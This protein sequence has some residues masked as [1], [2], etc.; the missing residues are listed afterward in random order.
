M[1]YG[2]GFWRT[3]GAKGLPRTRKAPSSF[4]LRARH[5]ITALAEIG[6]ETG[7]L[8]GLE[9]LRTDQL[10]GGYAT[11]LQTCSLP[12]RHFPQRSSVCRFVTILF[13][14]GALTVSHAAPNL[15]TAIDALDH[16]TAF[17]SAVDR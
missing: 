1:R 7:L 6:F 17:R 9:V 13:R 8:D 11:N 15:S 16:E 14:P 3:T 2:G 12:L 5:E 10:I 4:S